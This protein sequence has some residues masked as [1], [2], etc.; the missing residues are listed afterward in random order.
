MI[1]ED[2]LSRSRIK[3]DLRT[4]LFV[5][6]GAGSGKT[7]ALVGRI[8][9][10]VL[11]EAMD[12]RSIV[13][14][15]FTEKA[16]NEL[17]ER[18]IWELN[19]VA[20]DTNT[21][22]ELRQQRAIAAL[23][24]VDQAPLG[25]IHSFSRRILTR[26]SSL[27]NLPAEIAVMDTT[28][29]EIDFGKHWSQFTEQV[30]SEHN[31]KSVLSILLH[32]KRSD[33]LR[34]LAKDLPK[35]KA[36]IDE[37]RKWCNAKSSSLADEDIEQSL[38][39]ILTTIREYLSQLKDA[40]QLCKDPDDSLLVAVVSLVQRLEDLLEETSS[41]EILE[42]LI[43]LPSANT[44]AEKFRLPKNAGRQNS[45]ISTKKEL[46]DGLNQ[47]ADLIAAG[48]YELIDKAL[49]AFIFH[50]TDFVINYR[51]QRR[52]KG[53]LSFDDLIDFSIELLCDP[54]VG[55]EA[56]RELYA[57]YK[58]VM[59]DEFQ[60]TDP[61]Q[62]LLASLVTTPHTEAFD[63]NWKSAPVTPG[64]LFLVGDP[65]QA[66]YRFRG[67]DLAVFYTAQRR[68]TE[69]GELIKLVTNFRS[70]EGV[71]RFIN[72]L[73]EPV[74][75]CFQTDVVDAQ[76]EPS[77]AYEPLR[78]VRISSSNG[79]SGAF[80][81]RTALVDGKDQSKV[82]TTADV[83]IAEA[84]AT[85]AAIAKIIEE[86]WSVLDNLT[87]GE[88][89]ARFGD[90]TILVPKRTALAQ[91]E[92]ALKT[93][94]IPYVLDVSVD[95][96]STQLIRSLILTLWS[97][98]DP[99]DEVNTV[100]VLKS[101]L[102]QI[103]NENLVMH[104]IK[105]QGT[106]RYLDN[107]S[108]S[109][110]CLVGSAL[111]QLAT[112]R[113][114]VINMSVSLCITK[115]VD[116][117]T[118][119]ES[120]AR[121]EDWQMQWKRLEWFINQAVYW[122]SATADSLGAFLRYVQR[123]LLSKNYIL[124]K[125]TKQVDEDAVTITTIHSAK[126][127]EY[128]ICIVSAMST[129]IVGSNNADTQILLDRDHQIV[130]KF[131]GQKSTGYASYLET[132][133]IEELREAQRLLYVA[134]TRARDH[135]VVSL[136]RNQQV[137]VKSF[138]SKVTY[139]QLVT[140]SIEE[141]PIFVDAPDLFAD[142]DVREYTESL[143]NAKGYAQQISRAQRFQNQQKDTIS[144][145]ISGYEKTIFNLARNYEAGAE[146]IGVTSASKNVTRYLGDEFERSGGEV[147]GGEVP[148]L[149]SRNRPGKIGTAV[150]YILKLIDLSDHTNLRTV[151]EVVCKQYGCQEYLEDVVHMAEAAMTCGTVR[152][153]LDNQAKI[154]KEVFVSR[155]SDELGVWFE[156]FIDLLIEYEN[157]VEI[158]D[159]KSAAVLPE[160]NG[161]SFP[162]YSYQ[163]AL[164]AWTLGSTY[165]KAVRGKIIYIA[166]EGAKE[167]EVDIESAVQRLQHTIEATT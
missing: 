140:A 9:S 112:L 125:T 88:R 117:F 96:L 84:E 132:Q 142:L 111:S 139:A 97:I 116:Y 43:R 48:V 137:D 10:L 118:L 68:L 162:R 66:I 158:V 152:K 76:T 27:A 73:C 91:L 14:I 62:I 13:A 163:I 161:D 79:P 46:V 35:S 150:H 154:K 11:E 166:P 128:P 58:V 64:R 40:E 16:A 106:F 47:F 135:L 50:L 72:D 146:P 75:Q 44:N 25:T 130:Y 1:L 114:E 31:F 21:S 77:V 131:M 4:S 95:I 107:S 42:I 17:R 57:T 153:A 3:E 101:F 67:A 138:P 82:L 151:A 29:F 41:F 60:D 26:L 157:H 38:N 56:R 86:R 24:F 126:G 89:P 87:D 28:E 149:Q 22:S 69:V 45:W 6:A 133:K 145:L 165:K 36:I 134:F 129:S 120:T 8:L 92:V 30:L 136:Y 20:S 2:D 32:T 12:I 108:N 121:L 71:C 55:T 104:R 102:F 59:L 159:F 167:V 122:T 83:R 141:F 148:E 74:F 155:V 99:A 85:A 110:T 143:V 164:Y 94:K 52:S 78:P 123:L 63:R 98:W 156:G 90:I 23:N 160:A 5:E 81:G 115:V 147:E 19:E 105:C 49:R 65:K 127:L 80:I 93:L 70:T 51:D 124:D 119:F 109:C 39:S 54:V 7:S 103:T 18:L 144:Q 113:R 33:S 53:R 100:S 34:D 15:T 61:A 37:V